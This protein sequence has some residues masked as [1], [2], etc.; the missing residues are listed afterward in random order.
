TP[1]AA[2]ST[3]RPPTPDS[4]RTSVDPLTEWLTTGHHVAMSRVKRSN[5][6]A[7]ASGTSTSFTTAATSGPTSPIVVLPFLGARHRR[8]DVG[9]QHVVPEGLD[10]APERGHAPPIDGVQPVPPHPVGPDQ[11][12][13]LQHAQMLGHGGATDRQVRRDR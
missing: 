12:G 13:L 5:A 2:V 1:S 3:I 10:V 8:V 11:A 9:R 7:A 4:N 6:A